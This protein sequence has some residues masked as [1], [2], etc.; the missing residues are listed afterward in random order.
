[1]QSA[2]ELNHAQLPQELFQSRKEE[3]YAATFADYN[4]KEI[5]L[6]ELLNKVEALLQREAF[7]ILR[8]SNKKAFA[9]FDAKHALLENCFDDEYTN[10][11]VMPGIIVDTNAVSVTGSEATWKFGLEEFLFYDHGMWISS[12]KIN[13]W[14]V[15]FGGFIVILA[16]LLLILA[17]RRTKKVIG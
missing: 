8:E 13:W 6:E 16:L 5:E 14:A 2:K 9:D 10:R 7:G 11:V 15:V 3:L 4:I 1:M 17:P 12:R